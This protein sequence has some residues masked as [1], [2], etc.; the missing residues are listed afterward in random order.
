MFQK[1]K[2][3]K[4]KHFKIRNNTFIEKNSDKT[5]SQISHQFINMI[6]EKSENV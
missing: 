1:K 4:K 5:L 6:R 2:I 3:P